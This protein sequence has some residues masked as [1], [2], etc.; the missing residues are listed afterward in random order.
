M[1]IKYPN[2]TRGIRD[3][4]PVQTIDILPTIHD[5]L[6]VESSWEFDG[7]SLTDVDA[8]LRESVKLYHHSLE[9]PITL[10]KEESQRFKNKRYQRIANTFTLNDP[11]ATLF[12]H[13]EALDYVGKSVEDFRSK[14]VTSEMYEFS[15]E[16]SYVR[17]KIRPE[18]H[19]LNSLRVIASVNGTVVGFG[20]P[21]EWEDEWIFSFVI[22][23]SVYGPAENNAT[24]LI[25][26]M[27]P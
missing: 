15:Y 20:V 21:Y 9:E 7:Q 14:K 1:L 12:W 24:V 16:A 8:P 23:D 22:P 6:G 17:G 11:R 13:G 25:I 5:V 27:D 26:E 2:Q 18:N 3:D 4:R 10:S 19:D